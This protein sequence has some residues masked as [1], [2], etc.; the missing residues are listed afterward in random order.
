[1]A[2][3]VAWKGKNITLTEL[4]QKTG[5]DRSKLYNRIVT[6]G[7]DV[8]K[9]V[10]SGDL[11]NKRAATYTYKGKTLTI[12]GWAKELGVSES[13]LYNRAARYGSKNK[14]KIFAPKSAAKKPVAKKSAAKKLPAKAA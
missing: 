10:E 1:M 7:L 8:K 14:D 5:I 4:A 9:A 11:R 6:Q 3:T 2:H 12:P 13:V